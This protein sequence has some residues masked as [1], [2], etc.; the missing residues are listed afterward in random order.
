MKKNCKILVIDD[1]IEITQLLKILLSSEGYEV[2][3][4]SSAFGG[5]ELFKKQ[6]FDLVVLDLGL[7]DLEGE[8]LCKIIRKESDTP[9][10]ILSAKENVTGKVLCFEYGADDY[11]T[12]PFVNIELLARIKAVLRRYASENEESSIDKIQYKNITLDLISRKVIVEK[13]EI[14]FT[15]KEFDVFLFLIKRKGEIVKRDT[16]ISELWG[17]NSLYKWSRS[18]DVHIQHIRNK[19]S[20][21]YSDIIKTVSG[22]G[23]KV[24]L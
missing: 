20:P 16:L 13:T 10:I 21:Y 9:I 15:P 23:Y 8:H 22:T 12:K 2:V 11:I 7:P 5:L 3:S 17:K 19:L 4:S 6:N 14:D 18:L 1:D 24:D